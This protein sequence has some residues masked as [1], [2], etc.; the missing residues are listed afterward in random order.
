M[1]ISERVFIFRLSLFLGVTSLEKL[2]F[3]ENNTI[4]IG[5]KAIMG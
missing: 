5:V 4:V 3:Y 1:D 2:V